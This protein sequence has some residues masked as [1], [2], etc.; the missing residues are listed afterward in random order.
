MGARRAPPATPVIAAIE[1]G[2]FK[3]MQCKAALTPRARLASWVL[4]LG[5]VVVQHAGRI[6]LPDPARIVLGAGDDGV[7]LVVVRAGEDFVAMALEHLQALAG[8]Y[9]PEP[10]GPVAGRSDDLGAV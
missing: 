3:F 7:P 2:D 10:A 9:R 1:D 8:L 6:V 5:V 4:A